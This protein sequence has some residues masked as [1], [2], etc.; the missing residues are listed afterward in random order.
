LGD[1]NK[2]EFRVPLQGKGGIIIDLAASVDYSFVV[3]NPLPEIRFAT[4]AGFEL[5]LLLDEKNSLLFGMGSWEGV[6]T[7]VI[8]TELPFQGTLSELIYERSGRVS[9]TQY[10]L[11]W[12]RNLIHQF[13][14][15]LYLRLTLNELMDVDYKEDMVFGFLSGPAEGFKRVV[16][17]ES[18][19]TGILML[20]AGLGGELFV[21]DWVSLGFDVGYMKGVDQSTLGNVSTKDDFQVGDGLDIVPPSQEGPDGRLWYQG[22][23]DNTY[24]RMRLDFDGWRALLRIN[25]YF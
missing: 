14:R 16:V 22:V 18:Q 21:R 3:E 15:N 19:A 2:K 7:S 24:H 23:S 25:F 13:K 17:I 1:L 12:R 4:E 9:T 6:S 5:Q 8:Q 11:G 20:Q 10:F